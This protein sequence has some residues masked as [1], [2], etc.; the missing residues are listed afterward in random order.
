MGKKEFYDDKKAIPLNLVS[1]DNI[2]ISNKVKNSSGTSKYF[3]GYLSDIDNVIPLCSILPQS[4]GYTKYF[5]N[6]EKKMSVK[7]EEDQCILNATAYG[8]KLKNCWV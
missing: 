8:I 5:D 3:V 6:G 2:A 4:S 1:V 7:F